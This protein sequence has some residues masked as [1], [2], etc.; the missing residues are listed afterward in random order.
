MTVMRAVFV[1]ALAASLAAQP[2]RRIPPPGI[3]IS[4]AD[5]AALEAKLAAVR[6]EFSA[7]PDLA[8]RWKA[9]DWALRYGEFFKPED[10]GKAH[11]LLDRNFGHPGLSVHGFRSDIDDSLQPYGLV[12]PPSY[13]PNAPGLWRLDVWLHGRG[14]TT[15]ELAF[16]HDRLTKPGE[17]TPRDTFVV[18]PFGRYCNAYK[19]AGE[20]D[21]FEAVADVM[22][23][24][25]IDPKRIAIRGFSMGG[26]GAWHLAAHHPGRW[27]AAAPGAGFVDT[28][29]YQKLKEKGLLPNEYE[30][31]LWRLTN[32]KDY[33]LNFFNLPV[34]AY[35]GEED[36]QKAAADIM[37]R[38]MGRHGIPLMHLIGPRTG[39][40]YEPAAKAELARRFDLLLERG[41]E[42]PRHIR[43]ET[44]TL[45]YH[46]SHWIA[47]ERLKAHWQRASVHARITPKGLAVTTKNVLQLAFDFAP[48]EAPFAAGEPVEVVVDE[49]AYRA[50]PPASDRSWTFRTPGGR[51]GKVPGLQGPIDDAFYS[52]F[53]FVRPSASAPPWAKAE[54]DRAAR[55]WRRIFRGDALVRDEAALTA[56][57]FARANL[58]LWGT[59]QSSALMARWPAPASWPDD[60]AH[61]LLAIFPNP[62]HPGR[63]IVWNSGPTF[64][65]GHHYTN[66][67]QTAKLPD[68]AIV[69]T[70]APPSD[71]RPG[72]IVEAGFFDDDWKMPRR[73]MTPETGA[74]R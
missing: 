38:E 26:A 36:P 28:A 31:T 21:V 25:P 7:S 33:A 20:T 70:S 63:Y 60:P 23:R 58:V 53:I 66:A 48:G 59:P 55:E 61:V 42:T 17:F 45:R 44:F 46:R 40:K 14:E 39:H 57:D 67:Q 41:R 12:T 34:I 43:F 11:D 3:A 35:S 15:L 47:I 52:R 1:L 37:A 73:K 16:L 71:T 24:Y 54:F 2:P 68:W 10:V 64:R 51:S 19:F 56:E 74:K 9:V 69:D 6:E 4:A 8:V 65:E 27:A 30:Q 32:A 49:F 72:R 50:P 13:T 22:R 62:D 18:H 5:R 29:E